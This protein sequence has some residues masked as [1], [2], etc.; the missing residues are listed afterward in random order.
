MNIIPKVRLSSGETVPIIDVFS[1]MNTAMGDISGIAKSFDWHTED[2]RESGRVLFDALKQLH[3]CYMAFLRLMPDD[4][5]FDG[6]AT[7]E[8]GFGVVASEYVKGV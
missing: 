2:G 3:L 8:V 6:K 5:E 1:A 4:F 7:V